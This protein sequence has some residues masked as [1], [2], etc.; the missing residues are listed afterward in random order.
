MCNFWSL[1][2]FEYKKIFM[3]KSVIISIVFSAIFIILYSTFF[4]H[5]PTIEKEIEYSRAFGNKELN[6]ELILESSKAYQKVDVSKTNYNKTEEYVTNALPYRNVWLAI[7]E[8]YSVKTD[9]SFGAK[10]LQNITEEQAENYYT[11]RKEVILDYIDNLDL[12]DATRKKV[13]EME[14]N[15]QAPFEIANYKGF[16]ILT[17]SLF[18]T[19]IV[20]FLLIG[21]IIS[22]IFS[23]E[24]S[25]GADNLLLSSKNSKIVFLSK[26]FTVISITIMLAVLFLGITIGLCGVKYGFDAK[27]CALQIMSPLSWL[28]L[29]FGEFYSKIVICSILGLIVFSSLGAFISSITKQSFVVMSVLTL[30]VFLAMINVASLIPKLSI[31]SNAILPLNGFNGQSISSSTYFEFF[32]T[33]FPQ[34]NVLPIIYVIFTAILMVLAARNFKRH[35][36]C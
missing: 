24:Y 2:G 27:D 35:Q 26:M 36:V 18:M 11:Y 14:N 31:F 5:Y 12:S 4:S 8:V 30:N 15:I 1:V 20:I 7:N 33:A 32:G 23:N 21:Y 3:R 28:D 9:S 6:A 34:Y 16:S 22:P 25:T 17:T 13:I 10:E 29:T 19:G